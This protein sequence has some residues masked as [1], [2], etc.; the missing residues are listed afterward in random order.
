MLLAV[1]YQVVDV[2]KWQ[3]WATPFSWIGANALAL[4]FLNDILDFS[5]FAARFVGGDF[6]SELNRI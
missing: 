3:R 6:A 1:A 5:S 2:W 4:Y